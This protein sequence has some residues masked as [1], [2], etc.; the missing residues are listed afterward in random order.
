MVVVSISTD[1]YAFTTHA[2]SSN[3]A[4][5]RITTLII[6]LVLTCLL[7]ATSSVSAFRQGRSN[8]NIGNNQ[9]RRQI[10][11][12]PKLQK[13]IGKSSNSSDAIR[14]F[15]DPTS[16][17]EYSTEYQLRTVVK[18]L[19]QGAKSN[20]EERQE[21]VKK[22]LDDLTGSFVDDGDDIIND[23]EPDERGSFIIEQQPSEHS[24][25]TDHGII[26]HFCFL[27][28]GLNGNPDDLSYL[29]SVMIKSA[30]NALHEN[31]NKEITDDQLSTRDDDDRK[32]QGDEQKSWN[33]IIIHNCNCNARNT[34]DGIETGGQRLLEEMLHIVR[35]NVKDHYGSEKHE[36]IDAIIDITISM[37][38]NSLGGIYSRYA[39]AKLAQMSTEEGYIL[40]DNRIRVA[41]N[42]FCTTA[43]PHLGI[44]S[45][46]YFPLPRTAEI[47]IGKVV[48]QTLQDLLRTTPIIKQMCICPT[49]LQPLSSFRKRILYAN[50]HGDFPVPTQTA[51]FLNAASTYPH[52][53]SPRS[54][55]M[56]NDETDSK[57]DFVVAT[58]HTPCAADKTPQ[59]SPDK[60]PKE[61]S[62]AISNDKDELLEMSNSLD[63][64]GWKKVFVKMPIS[65]DIPRLR[66]K[67]ENML[68]SLSSSHGDSSHSSDSGDM[69][70][71]PLASS[72]YG[73]AEEE[74]DLVGVLESKDV[75]FAVSSPHSMHF[76]F[77]HNM[78]VAFARGRVSR[79]AFKAG[80]PLM[81][82]LAKEIVN[83][84]IQHKIMKQRK[85]N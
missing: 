19:W 9:T 13:I 15:S 26:T 5:Y 18:E 4:E 14:E 71:L 33:R 43:T 69:I 22:L 30:R 58:L 27:V 6:V 28:H 62:P 81:N 37:I 72:D 2:V 75:K 35:S 82:D 1:A 38:G 47:G 77:A 60:I 40:I 84:I 11:I 53:I 16:D 17:T 7:L 10:H 50:S 55:S 67:K 68:S 57:N 49:F 51:A 74:K 39:I 29:Q 25:S 61:S 32:K 56:K 76:P 64:L 83:E 46:T 21:Y 44:A 66:K 59:T 3:A 41:F 12:L 34:G 31:P 8:S 80:R 23:I 63:Q 79:A 45:H 24:I 36:N 52:H 85:E 70:E 78:M 20:F 54:T 65:V 73:G 48:G 42:I